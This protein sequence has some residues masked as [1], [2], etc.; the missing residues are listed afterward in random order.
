MPEIT[1]DLDGR[2]LRVAVVCGRFN[3]LI[4]ERL[5]AGCRDGLV[6][7]GASD[8]DITVVWVPGSF[9]IPLAAQQAARSGRYDAV[10]CLGAVIR[11]ATG[12]YE[13]VA[14]QAAAGI[15]RAGLDSGVP[16]IFGV[17]TTDTIEQAI[18]RAGTKAGNK[19]YDAAVAAIETVNVLRRLEKGPG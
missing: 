8:D 18:E 9:E 12:H 4:T 13:H 10:I 5:L 19:G 6:R 3:D 16:V 17:L 11:G 1:G 14:G 15:A 7:H 2:G